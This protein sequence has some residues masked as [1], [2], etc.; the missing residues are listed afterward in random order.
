MPLTQL[1][2]RGAR[3]RAKPYKL[4]DGQGMYL[5]V[6]PNGSKYWRLKYRYAGKERLLALGVYPEVTLKVARQRRTE[7]RQQLD[8]GADPGAQKAARKHAQADSFE[9]VALE[10]FAKE[11]PAWDPSHS[12]R[13]KRR[14]ERDVFPY[15]GNRPIGEVSAPEVLALARRIVD[16]G[17]VE[18]AHRALQ[19]ISQVMRYAV[20]TGRVGSDPTCCPARRTAGRQIDSP[21]CHHRPERAGR[22]PACDFRIQGDAHR[23]LRPLAES[24]RLRPPSRAPA[25]RVG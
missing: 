22:T 5:H 8:A 24:V 1:T 18:T 16:R 4:A 3:S 7:A 6:M 19:N 25:C 2:I 17:A 20:V 11:E 15:I 21:R 23:A 12:T 14:L 9:A 10:W 13:I